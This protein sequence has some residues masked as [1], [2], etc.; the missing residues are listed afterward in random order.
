MNLNVVSGSATTFPA[1]ALITAINSGGLWFGGI[2]RAIQGVAGDTFHQQ[3]ED[4]APLTDGQTIFARGGPENRGNFKN[5]VFVVDDLT[6]P[7]NEL[8]TSALLA[9]NTEGCKMVTLPAMRWGVMRG[10]IE[11]T[12]TEWASEI[13]EGIEAAKKLKVKIRSLT[14]IIYNDPEVVKKLQDELLM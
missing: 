7:L 9:A 3:A 2:D 1:D 12:L 13:K 5:V 14:I 11:K 8:V 4:S 6:K 10:V